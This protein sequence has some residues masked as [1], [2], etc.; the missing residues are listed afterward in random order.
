MGFDRGGRGGGRGRGFGRGRG[1]F[2]GGYYAFKFSI[3][4]AG[5]FFFYL[6]C[7]SRH[8]ERGQSVMIKLEIIIEDICRNIFCGK[9]V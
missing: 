2:R 8:F 4:C 1:D 6:T 5:G 3:P 9:K 7:S